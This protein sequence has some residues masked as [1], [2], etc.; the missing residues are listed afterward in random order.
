MGHMEINTMIGCRVDCDFCPQTL[1]MNEYSSQANVENLSYGNPV[2]MSFEN[3]KTC[4]D[5]IPKKMEVSFGG[6]S[7]PFLNPECS[8]MI[9]YAYENEHSVS[10]FTTLVGM[11]L[12]DVKQLENIQFD[13]FLVHLPDDPMYAKIA[14]NKNYI[15][16]LKKLLSSN[17]KNIKGMAM[18]PLHSK[19][20]E[21]L[22]TEIE[23]DVMI[24]RAG[25]L[26]N[27]KP[28]AK[29]FGPVTCN[30]ASKQSLE[31]KLD[32]N[33]L[34][35]NGDVSLCCMDYGLQN[36]LGN[37]LESDYESLFH[38]DAFEKI[39]KKM[40]SQ[41]SDIICRNCEESIL[42]SELIERRNIV[43]NYSGNSSANSLIQLYQNLLG[44]LPDKEGFDYFY[45]K[46]SNGELTIQNVE[47]SIKESFEYGAT[48]KPKI[49]KN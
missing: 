41:D 21:V 32:Y 49:S 45:S 26:D 47:D 20:K 1:L 31:D 18:G 42:E 37:L 44:R 40:K 11:T 2:L 4:L 15:E 28:T 16:V 12:E 30:L 3:F 34:L 6:F 17:I 7:E 25:N 9:I 13:E 48:R 43:K 38:S 35:P 10:V 14:V 23:E 36:I 46:I 19:I 39:W 5:K 27:V 22:D 29:K 8:K 33:V 24:S